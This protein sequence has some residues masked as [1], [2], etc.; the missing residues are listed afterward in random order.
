MIILIV[1]V[2][3]RSALVGSD[4]TI[5]P[6]IGE[7]GIVPTIDGNL[8]SFDTEWADSVILN[9]TI[10]GYDT[11]I[12]ILSDETNLYIGFNYTSANYVAVN[13]TSYNSTSD[14]NLDTHDWVALQIDN[15]LDQQTYG[16]ANNPDD[17]MVV[18]QMNSSAYDGFANGTSLSYF[19]D[20]VANGT[21]DGDAVS[22]NETISGE[23]HL[24][25]EFIKPHDVV[26]EEGSD[27]NLNRRIL[28]FK[29]SLFFNTTSNSSLSQAASSQ[30][31]SMRINETGTGIAL[32]SP[33]NTTVSI[34][35]VGDNTDGMYS[36]LNTS[37][38]LFG[39]DTTVITNNFSLNDDVYLNIFVIT[40]NSVISE[41]QFEALKVYLELGGRAI[42]FLSNSSTSVSDNVAEKFNMDFLP[43]EVFD[44]NE[45]VLQLTAA[46]LVS[47]PYLGETSLA[48]NT[49]VSAMTFTSSAFN[50][51]SS[52]NKTENPY[53]YFQEYH[54]YDL[55]DTTFEI[56]Y[57]TSE[58][59]IESEDISLGVSFDLLKGGRISL[60]PSTSMV[61]SDYLTIEDN[62]IYL[63]RLLP[64][65]S[66]IV[67]TL[68][69]NSVEI[70]SHHYNLS[71][72]I[73]ITANVTDE[74]GVDVSPS[75]ISTLHLSTT[76]IDTTEL[77][78]SGSI[79]T[80][81]LNI[82]QDGSMT[83][84][85]YAFKEGYGFSEGTDQQLLVN[86]DVSL[87]NELSNLSVC[88]VLIFLVS[89]VLVVYIIL[90]TKQ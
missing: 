4:P 2:F 70:D 18:D 5:I 50:T 6:T 24:V 38:S 58:G 10:S 40:E 48:T 9:T 49:S 78:G 28:Q 73:S 43:N 12:R 60:F 23:E 31:F 39:F 57:N 35:I 37:L 20:T 17:V 45:T 34:N 22:A 87:G 71:D 11:S 55:F 85:T 42:F 33:S 25:Y 75:V 44:N 46:D 80:G 19:A 65:N 14:Q 36:G 72:Q 68:Q 3:S 54:M 66:R 52:D 90:K 88:L 84:K 27:Y 61:S 56:A 63:L 1:S 69:V 30:W 74:Y 76:T 29:I 81:T 26:D 77:T 67:N 8:T 82:T 21:I 47:M 64:W 51:S 7:S 53:V 16:S 41:D 89:V 59:Q 13:G 86:E 83:V 15:N 79:Y 32:E 62:L